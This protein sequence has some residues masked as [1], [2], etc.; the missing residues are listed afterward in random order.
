MIDAAIAASATAFGVS[1]QA[2]LSRVRPRRISDARQCVYYVAHTKFAFTYN[3]IAKLLARHVRTII[4]GCRN[5]AA[6]CRFD[7]EMRRRVEAVEAALCVQDCTST[8]AEC[9]FKKIDLSD[10]GEQLCDAECVVECGGVSNTLWAEVAIVVDSELHGG[11]IE[12]AYC[13]FTGHAR[14]ER[15]EIKAKADG[16]DVMPTARVNER[17]L[18][19]KICRKIE[20]A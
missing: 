9:I 20:N 12:E 4:A 8:L 19:A 13:T 16:V 18:E 14:V 1:R 5:I 6:W 11:T 10:D 17:A 2:I 7:A 15:L 3:K